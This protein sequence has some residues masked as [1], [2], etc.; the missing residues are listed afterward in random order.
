MLIRVLSLHSHLFVGI[1]NPDPSTRLSTDA[2][3]HR[4]V[5]ASNPFSYWRRSQMVHAALRAED[6]AADTF[7][8]VPFPIHHRDRWSSYIPFDATQHVRVFGEW[9]R[10]KVT[11]LEQQY[12]VKVWEDEPRM[13]E[14]ADIR[15]A[16]AD[17]QPVDHLVHPAV[18]PLIGSS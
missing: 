14:G 10:D 11:L 9:E 7:T 12:A 18:L 17:G 6:V 13:A 15:A 4:G 8:V 1:T 3:P 16:L 2:A 5:E